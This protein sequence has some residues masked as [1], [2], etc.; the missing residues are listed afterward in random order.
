MKL[1][2]AMAAAATL[3]LSACSGSSNA[4]TART[5]EEL[6]TATAT[7]TSVDTVNRRIGLTD[8]TDGDRFTVYAND[9]I[10]NLEQLA[11]GDTIVVNYYE[12]V[13]VDIATETDQVEPTTTVVAGRAPEGDKPGAIAAVTTTMV[14]EILDYNER[15]S[16]ASFLTPDGVAHRTTVKP[17]LRSFAEGLTPG[18]KVYVNITEAVAASIEEI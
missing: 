14:V 3:L 15:T 2:L 1:H 13:T 5:S 10:P 8:D 12:A 18:P 9:G 7:V 16:E 11:P 17:D 4:D 6:V